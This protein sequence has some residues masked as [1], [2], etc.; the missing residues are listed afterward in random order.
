MTNT[1]KALFFL[2]VS[3]VCTLG[4]ANAWSAAFERQWVYTSETSAAIYW[5]LGDITEAALG[6]VEF[7]TTEQL[8]QSTGMTRKP[9]WSHLH[10]LAGLLTDTTYYYRMVVVDTLMGTR[11]ESGILTF[12]TA[13]RPAAVRLPG[14]L[15]GPPYE[16]DQPDT[17]YIL[18]E[19]VVVDG[20]AFHI[21]APGV[22]LDLDGHTVTFGD[23]TDRQVFGVRFTYQGKGTLCNGHI[24]QGARSGWYS[25]AI[26]S[27]G[28]PNPTE[29]FG[30]TTD[31]HLKCAYPVNF[32]S[33]ASDVQI[34][35]N[36]FYSRVT[37]LESRHYPGNTILRMYISGG[38]I[39]IHD[40]LLTEGCHRGIYLGNPGF[41]V[42]VDHNDIRHHQ[43]YVNGYALIP[44]ANSDFH[45]NRVTSTGRGAHLSKE[46]IQFHDNYFD[47]SGHMHLSDLPANTRPFK[48]RL[49]ELHGI[50]LE[51]T[52]ARNCKIYDNYVRI[53]QKLPNDSGG[54][55]PA[56][57][58][59]ENGVYLR[60]VPTGSSGSGVTDDTQNWETNR[61]RYYFLGYSAG[62]PP[63]YI[64]GNDQTTLIA[65]LDGAVG[66]EYTIYMKWQ[67]VPPT[68]LNIACYDVAANNEVYGNTF[69]AITKYEDGDIWHGGYGS[70]GNWASAIMLINMNNG[71]AP[72]GQYSIYVHDNTFISNDLFLNSSTDVDMTVRVENNTFNLAGAPHTIE[73]ASRLR[74]IGTALEAS[75]LAGNNQFSL[76]AKKKTDINDDGAINIADALAYLIRL[77][78]QPDNSWADWNVDGQIDLVDVITL[79]KDIIASRE[80]S[81]NTPPLA[82]QI[83]GGSLSAFTATQFTRLLSLGM[84]GL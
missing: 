33:Q 14:D 52:G 9:R 54:I 67:Y 20:D 34:H 42:E 47:L 51:G 3:S 39:H 48:H 19:D 36:H 64:G 22:T 50:K 72:Q 37:E 44:N 13:F 29:I 16:L 65:N 63:A 74:A 26:R 79:L 78:R 28:R 59:I 21:A 17:Y 61:W 32:H 46:N 25:C 75:V 27:N 38:N 73:R 43:Q 83:V 53:T 62:F 49:I 30:I 35:H 60:S 12:R 6:Q 84:D 31:V 66:S 55:G 2:S 45:H 10:R 24:A 57:D 70:T 40:N 56:E 23:N 41:N 68:P 80:T 11:T 81:I 8:G 18:T 1:L 69:I 5:Q 58:K 7:G 82:G 77:R 15:G 4:V 71:P 76:S